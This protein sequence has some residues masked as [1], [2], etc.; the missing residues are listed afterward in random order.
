MACNV[1][2]FVLL[3]ELG[4]ERINYIMLVD[5]QASL[6]LITVF[7]AQYSELLDSTTR[8]PIHTNYIP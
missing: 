3:V 4:H 1:I 5:H 7:R 8:I 6:A 2:I